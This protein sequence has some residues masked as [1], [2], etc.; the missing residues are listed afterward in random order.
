MK[1]IS[2]RHWLLLLFFELLKFGQSFSPSSVSCD[3]SH[4][5][6]H[7]LDYL[8]PLCLLHQRL[9]LLFLRLWIY[10]RE[11]HL[12][13]KRNLSLTR[14]SKKKKH[15]RLFC[16]EMEQNREA[17]RDIAFYFPV[18]CFWFLSFQTLSRVYNPWI[19]HS[20]IS[21]LTVRRN[22]TLRMLSY[23]TIIKLS[24]FLK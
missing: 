14:Q 3:S 17:N 23:A 1:A 18:R 10:S 4:L 12:I 20:K 13:S 11:L 19:Q 7:L 22:N 21:H 9:P 8:L 2:R 24:N 5:T 6:F 15:C 16:Q